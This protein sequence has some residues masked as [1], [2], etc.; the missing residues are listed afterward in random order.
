LIHLVHNFSL[1]QGAGSIGSH[2]PP[3]RNRC[4]AGGTYMKWIASGC[5]CG[6][7]AGAVGG[8]GGSTFASDVFDF[9]F[10]SFGNFGKAATSI[11]SSPLESFGG[12][13]MSS[14]GASPIVKQIRDRIVG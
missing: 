12:V 9:A 4:A 10:D 2:L 7:G 8:G 1:A 14:N 13:Q 11:G 5:C 6:T 3:F